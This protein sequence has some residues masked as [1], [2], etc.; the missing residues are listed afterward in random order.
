MIYL[1][2][3]KF[4]S[5]LLDD[6]QIIICNLDINTKEMTKLKSK[7]MKCKFSESFW[8]TR[9]LLSWFVMRSCL[10]FWEIHQSNLKTKLI[11]F[12][13]IAWRRDWTITFCIVHFRFHLELN[14]RKNLI[15][16]SSAVKNQ[17]SVLK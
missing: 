5:Y 14:K 4:R 7:Q 2:I 10:G 8:L 1:Q 6:P 12:W 3:W 9:A 15:K 11:I 17:E 16:T 13:K